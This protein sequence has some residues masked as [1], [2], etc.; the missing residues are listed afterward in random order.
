MVAGVGL[1]MLRKPVYAAHA[2]LLITSTNQTDVFNPQQ[3]QYGAA[4]RRVA[5]E[6]AVVKSSAV[7]ALVTQQLGEAPPLSVTGASDAD[8]ITIT[9]RNSD[10][11]RAMSVANAYA[12]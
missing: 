12:N 1:T 5:T 4:Q 9:A 7:A 8:I 10:P 11:R 3:D 2:T 6:S